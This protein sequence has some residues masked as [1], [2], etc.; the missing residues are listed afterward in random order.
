MGLRE[1]PI[2]WLPPRLLDGGGLRG[3]GAAASD[4]A[5]LPGHQGARTGPGSEVGGSHTFGPEV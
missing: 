3:E 4:T 1:A 2:P 5:N